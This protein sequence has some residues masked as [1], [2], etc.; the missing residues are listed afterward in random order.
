MSIF[1][2]K[3]CAVRLSEG[4]PIS[5]PPC[6]GRSLFLYRLPASKPFFRHV[7]EHFEFTPFPA[8][9]NGNK[10]IVLCHLFNACSPYARYHVRVAPPWSDCV[11]VSTPNVLVHL[12]Y[13]PSLS[14]LHLPSPPRFLKN[15]CFF[16]F[17]A[18]FTPRLVDPPILQKFESVFK[19]PLTSLFAKNFS[20]FCDAWSPVLSANDLR[21]T[22][23]V[24][25]FVT[26][27]VFLQVISCTVSYPGVKVTENFSVF[28][29]SS[30][31]VSDQDSRLHSSFPLSSS[32]FSFTILQFND[33]SSL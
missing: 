8:G 31:S 18:A 33:S 28:F 26:L 32:L 2:Q 7:T 12:F 22:P 5:V 14:P 25:L 15:G 10:C 29:K 23:L 13:G 1:G 30:R 3:T 16:L 17:P 11:L 24:H 4:L 27:Y 20:S 19:C 9:S 6:W 21:L